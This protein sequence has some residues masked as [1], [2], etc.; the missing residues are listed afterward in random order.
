MVKEDK[1]DYQANLFASRKTGT[2]LR[3]YRTLQPLKS[4]PHFIST[5]I[6]QLIHF[7]KRNH[8]ELLEYF[9][10]IFIDT[11]DFIPSSKLSFLPILEELDT[12]INM[13][14]CSAEGFDIT[15]ATGPVGI[16][17]IVFK[18]CS[19]TLSKSFFQ[20]FNKLNKQVYFRIFGN[21]Q[22]YRQLSNK[23][24]NLISKTTN[25]YNS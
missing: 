25:K 6:L 7:H 21:Y 11:S 4:Q 3:Y 17:P 23:T 24:A 16:S 8:L 22:Q 14:E 2:L 15:K 13:L 19:K 5:T 20:V 9:A 10:S 1:S 12:S 18:N